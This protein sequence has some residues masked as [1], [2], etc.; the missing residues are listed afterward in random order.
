[1]GWE[2]G[3]R[4]S[5]WGLGELGRATLAWVEQPVLQ[6]NEVGN[7]HTQSQNPIPTSLVPVDKE[8][9]EM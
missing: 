9:E 2:G 1:M 4:D 7:S 8:S 6:T 3:S 5:N